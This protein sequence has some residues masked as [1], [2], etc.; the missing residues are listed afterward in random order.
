VSR[1]AI[2]QQRI[3]LTRHLGLH[4][5]DKPVPSRPNSGHLALDQ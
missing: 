3:G 4:S 1:T 5:S 2:V